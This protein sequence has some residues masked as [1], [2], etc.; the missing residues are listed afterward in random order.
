MANGLKLYPKRKGEGLMDAVGGSGNVLN[1]IVQNITDNTIVKTEST[2][3]LAT[4]SIAGIIEIATAGETNAGTDYT[5]AVCPGGLG[6]S[7]F[8]RKTAILKVIAE[9]TALTTGDGKGYLPIP[10]DLNGLDLLDIDAIVYTASSSGLPTIQIYNVT[11]SVDML[12]TRI[13]IDETELTSYTALTP[14][15]IN[16]SYKSVATGDILRVD[17]DVAGTDTTGLDIIFTFGIT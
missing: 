6:D 11:D 1:T 17:V 13:T 16:T 4:L 3:K 2:M 7:I 15:V 14:S 5:R 9:A 10:S 12:S 8:G